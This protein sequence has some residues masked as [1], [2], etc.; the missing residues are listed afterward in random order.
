MGDAGAAVTDSPASDPPASDPPVTVDDA[1]ILSIEQAVDG[2]LDKVQANLGFPYSTDPNPTPPSTSLSY[3]LNAGIEVSL[4]TEWPLF[5]GLTLTNITLKASIDKFND[6][7][8]NLFIQL[9]ASATIGD[10]DFTVTGTIPRLSTEDPISFVLILEVEGALNSIDPTA[11]LTDLTNGGY[12]FDS[13]VVTYQSKTSTTTLTCTIDDDSSISLQDIAAD[14]LLNAA[15]A[16]GKTPTSHDLNQEASTKPVP[17]SV[18]VDMSWCSSRIWGTQRFCI[19]TFAASELTQV[20]LKA[21]FELD[22]QATSQLT[23]TGMGIY[24]DITNPTSSDKPSV[25]NGYAYGSVVIANAVN[26]YA[27]VAGVSQPSGPRQFALGL[28]VSYDP[29]ANLGASP[30]SIISDPKFLGDVV[31]T[32]SWTFPKSAPD[33]ANISDA[34]TS[35]NAQMTMR[36]QQSADPVNPSNDLTSIVSMQASLVVTGQWTI[37]D[38]IILEQLSLN[39]VVLPGTAATQN[40]IS[41]YAQLLGV[42][43][44]SQTAVG[45]TQ[46]KVVL[47][48]M[49]L[50]NAKEQ[51]TI[52]TASISAYY[53]ASGLNGYRDA[54]GVNA[55]V[56]FMRDTSCMLGVPVELS[57]DLA[58][59]PFR[60]F[61]IDVKEAYEMAQRLYKVLKDV[62][63]LAEVAEDIAATMAELAEL[64]GIAEIAGSIFAGLTALG[65]AKDIVQG[66]LDKVFGKD[67]NNSSGG[68][69]N[70]QDDPSSNDSSNGSSGGGGNPYLAKPS[71]VVGGTLMSPGPAGQ[72]VNLVVYPK[73]KFGNFLQPFDSS[74]LTLNI[75]LP[76]V[77]WENVAITWS[78]IPNGVQTSLPKPS[79]EAQMGV[80]YSGLNPA[81]EVDFHNTIQ[82]Q[83]SVFSLANSDVTYPQTLGCF[84][85]GLIV[86]TPKDQYGQPRLGIG[87][88]PR[89]SLTFV[90]QASGIAPSYDSS[91]GFVVRNDSLLLPFSL[92][93]VG[94]YALNIQDPSDAQSPPRNFVITAID[95]LSADKCIAYGEGLCSGLG[96]EQVALYV[97]LRN[98]SGV[99]YIPGPNEN[100]GITINLSLP[101]SA[102]PDVSISFSI[103]QDLLTAYYLRPAA[104]SYQILIKINDIP[105]GEGPFDLFVQTTAVAPSIANSIF[106]VWSVNQAHMQPSGL[107]AQGDQLQGLITTFDSQGH[108]WYQS[109]V[110]DSYHVVWPSVFAPGPLVDNSDGTYS[111][112]AVASAIGPSAGMSMSVSSTANPLLE[113]VDSPRPM[114]VSPPRQLTTLVAYGSGLEEGHDQTSTI[115]F[116]GFDQY[117]IEFSVFLGT[118]CRLRLLQDNL[119][120]TYSSPTAFSNTANYQMPALGAD[121]MLVLLSTMVSTGQVESAFK[122]EM[123]LVPCGTPS[124]TDPTKCYVFWKKLV[125]DDISS[126]TLYACDSSGNRRRQ[127]GDFVQTSSISN[128]PMILTTSIKDNLDGSYTINMMMPAAAFA[129]QTPAPALVI[130]VNGQ[131]IQATPFSFPLSPL[132]IIYSKADGSGLTTATLGKE[133]NFWISCFASNGQLSSAGFHSA[134]VYLLQNTDT[135]KYVVCEVSAINVGAAQVTYTIPADMGAG[136]YE[137]YIYVNSEQ[138]A[139]SPTTVNVVADSID[140][141]SQAYRIYRYAFANPPT[142][143]SIVAEPTIWTI[144]TSQDR[145]TTLTTQ[146][147]SSEVAT[148]PATFALNLPVTDQ[149]FQNGGFMFSFDITIDSAT[150]IRIAPFTQPTNQVTMTWTNGPNNENGVPDNT[151]S[152]IEWEVGG[153]A[154]TVPRSE[155][156]HITPTDAATICYHYMI[157][158]D[159]SQYLLYVFQAGQLVTQG[160]WPRIAEPAT[161]PSLGLQI[162]RLAGTVC[163]IGVSNVLTIPTYFRTKTR[164]TA[165]ADS[166]Q[167]GYE[168]SNAV[169][170]NSNTFWHSEWS[171]TLVPLPHDI[172]VDLNSIY[173]VS[174]LTYQPRQDGSPNGNIG[175][176]SIQLSLN[177]QNWDAPCATG[178]FADDS[179]SKTVTFTSQSARY[180]RLN[181]ITEAGNRGPWSSAADIMIS[182]ANP[183]TGGDLVLSEPWASKYVVTTHTPANL[184]SGGLIV[185]GT[186]K[187]ESDCFIYQS[188]VPEYGCSIAIYSLSVTNA[189]DYSVAKPEPGE[190]PTIAAIGFQGPFWSPKEGRWVNWGN[191]IEDIGPSNM[192]LIDDSTA[193]PNSEQD[194]NTVMV[195]TGKSCVTIFCNGV[196]QFSATA[197]LGQPI[198]T[199]IP[200]QL[201]SYWTSIQ[202]HALRVNPP[203]EITP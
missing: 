61:G 171:P 37:F 120:Y 11:L 126:A 54:A 45:S 104:G 68:P 26:L 13:V 71:L 106:S 188:P 91:K 34:V 200:P 23:V 128:T 29:N 132:P 22:W 147:G 89:L 116:R 121:P 179:S 73:D 168:P 30:Q 80:K 141:F 113:C 169:D 92:L 18:P 15:P 159:N 156:L 76:D 177:G 40:K 24:F 125:Q 2:L 192:K 198:T 85:Q 122:P 138:I 38:T 118:N 93:A 130:S 50:R 9:S 62:K 161:P 102:V 195:I 117:G 149:W 79:S 4:D 203:L 70:N 107:I 186:Q 199:L 115:S 20:Q 77:P 39:V 55:S 94:T 124:V 75:L 21:N 172:V 191:T 165:V 66:A 178:S 158:E 81:I 3:R 112:S 82:N 59:G 95:S 101:L 157:S 153:N 47:A 31:A 74:Q 160:S 202:Y 136:T 140:V 33:T 41:Y 111:M 65:A 162:K 150:P 154:I 97:K 137:C 148:D 175:D 67:S 182:Y 163:K 174:S 35:V 7:P 27:F 139:Q 53:I 103:T 170:G 72:E 69:S 51:A 16:P 78:T 201:I 98:Q 17:D 57:Y 183:E 32:D 6:S 42:V 173:L 8:A 19:L 90:N 99:P 52:F 194:S 64:A 43:S 44:P 28:T 131:P 25:I 193:E 114:I 189:F 133:A 46:Y 184:S 5:A 187:A 108:R 88:A 152:T 151:Q 10:L 185:D 36:L 167:H 143:W 84:S 83:P 105:L 96:G 119:P 135:P 56:T 176:Y 1:D 48:A 190:P 144:D 197:A 86:L 134:S 49:L 87:A 196:F 155:R 146:T 166:S 12:V 63:D 129:S 145:L 181:A 164:L 14:S 58:S 109:L 110:N 127:G 100:P 180:V 123:F 60:V 142:Q